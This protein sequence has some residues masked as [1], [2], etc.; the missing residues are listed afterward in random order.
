MSTLLCSFH[1][2]EVKCKHM[3]VVSVT[4]RSEMAFWMS[5]KKTV[6]FLRVTVRHF[7]VTLYFN[8]QQLQNPL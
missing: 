2:A 3:D 8:T 1:A 6:F 5:R 7:T 4:K